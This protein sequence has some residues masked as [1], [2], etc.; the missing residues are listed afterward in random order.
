MDMDGG[1]DLKLTILSMDSDV[2]VSFL[3]DHAAVN[4]RICQ[5]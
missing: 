2:A 4:L 5:I 1:V 3:S